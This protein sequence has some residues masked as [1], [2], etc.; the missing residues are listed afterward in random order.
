L[1]QGHSARLSSPEIRQTFI[2]Y[3]DVFYILE[4]LDDGSPDVVGFG[5]PRALRETLKTLFNFFGQANGK[6]VRILYA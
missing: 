4:V 3:L 5:A 2:S 1:S 6:H